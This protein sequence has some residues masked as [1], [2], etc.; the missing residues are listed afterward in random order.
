MV[1]HPQTLDDA[2]LSMHYANLQRDRLRRR[3][4]SRTPVMIEL[5]RRWQCPVHAIWGAGDVLIRHDAARL[6]EALAGCDLRALTL[7]DDAGH[8]VQYE[9]PEAFNAALLQGLENG[10]RD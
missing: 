2:A 7:I 10:M 8:W 9:R 3:R 4:I 6:R 1:L 5:Q